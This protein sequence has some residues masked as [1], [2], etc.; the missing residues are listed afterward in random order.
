MW[1]WLKKLECSKGEDGNNTVTVI[2][3]IGAAG[4]AVFGGLFNLI[5]DDD[6]PRN[7]GRRGG[8]E[9]AW[10]AQHQ[11]FFKRDHA[12]RRLPLGQNWRFYR[13]DDAGFAHREFDD[14]TWQ[15]I[16]ANQAWEKQINADYD[17]IAWYRKSIRIK[18]RTDH[19]L[20]LVLGKIDDA[21]ETYFNGHLI[22]KTGEFPPEEKTAWDA[23]RIYPIPE[24]LIRDDGLNVIAIRVY[25]QQGPG[26]LVRG[27]AAIF[28]SHLPAAQV[29]LNGE[30]QIARNKTEPNQPP[31]EDAA[32]STIIAPGRWDNQGWGDFDGTAWYRK[33][34]TWD[35]ATDADRLELSLGRI[36]DRDEVFLNGTRIGRTWSDGNQG[37][38][39][40][41]RRRYPF[42]AKLLQTGENEL[43]VKVNDDR[44]SG[45]IHAGPLG[46]MTAEDAKLYWSAGH[47]PRPVLKTVWDWLLGRG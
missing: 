8:Q 22:G 47:A 36:D 21:D 37:E 38:M 26:G 46:I 23:Q 16:D 6:E 27:G 32:W 28:E 2:A 33:S 9:S 40:N 45:G 42:P 29:N 5:L 34:F 14:S 41:Q 11:Q 4:A 3:S 30:W 13:G 31:G 43:L 12:D 7:G 39:W 10:V 17:G 24:K 20:F 25:D 35:A 1:A 44:Q 15:Y 18:I 19:P